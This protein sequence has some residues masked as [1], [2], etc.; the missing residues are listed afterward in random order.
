[1]DG[2]TWQRVRHLLADEEYARRIAAGTL[3]K[4]RL[5]DLILGDVDRQ[6]RERGLPWKQQQADR[7]LGEV[8]RPGTAHECPACGITFDPHDTSRAELPTPSPPLHDRWTN[9]DKVVA[10]PPEHVAAYERLGYQP[11]EP[12][13]EATLHATP[14]A[15]VDT[16]TRGDDGL[17]YCRASCAAG[18]ET[19]TL[20]D[21][22]AANPHRAGAGTFLLRYIMET[23]EGQRFADRAL[24]LDDR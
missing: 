24:G 8:K 16:P 19:V 22:L 5:R 14:P 17:L 7:L 2:D 4:G 18:V 20:D 9:G 10:V 1:M 12:D 21:W 13:V 3:D 23:A 11:L 15:N 6:A